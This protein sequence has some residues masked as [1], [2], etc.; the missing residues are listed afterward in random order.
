MTPL[1]LAL[2]AASP[3]APPVYQVPYRLTNTKHLMVR[4]KLNGKNYR[5]LLKQVAEHGA[6]NIAL[7][8]QGVLK[9]PASPGG[10]FVQSVRFYNPDGTGRE[11]DANRNGTVYAEWL[12]DTRGRRVQLVN[13]GKTYDDTAG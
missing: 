7:A 1:L 3:A 4:A 5:K 12:L 13:G 9:P 10:P 11:Y 2:L 6:E 8:L